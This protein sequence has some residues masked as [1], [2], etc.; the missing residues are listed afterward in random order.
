MG[1][2]EMRMLRWLCGNTRKYRVRNEYIREKVGVTPIENKLRENRLRWFGHIQ[3][4]RVDAPVR[5]SDMITIS[6]KRRGRGRP[7]L[8]WIDVI[9]DMHV[10]NVTEH[11]ALDWAEWR[12]RIHVADPK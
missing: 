6:G 4:R 11:I 5:K 1:V 3:R 2:A 7:K 9:K 10:M 12:P 8:S